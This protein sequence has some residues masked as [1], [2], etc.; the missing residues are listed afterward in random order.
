MFD[1]D[2]LQDDCLPS[3]PRQNI[4]C[5]VV[6]TV[7]QPTAENRESPILLRAH[8]NQP[9]YPQSPSP[10]YNDTNR[11]YDGGGPASTVRP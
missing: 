8:S 6:C 5:T 10:P 1:L 11:Y 2:T 4:V 7:T 3:Q 9:F